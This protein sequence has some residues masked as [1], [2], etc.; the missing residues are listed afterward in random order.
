MEGLG[1]DLVA[2]VQEDQAVALAGEQAAAEPVE[3]VIDN[4][5]IPNAI[6]SNEWLNSDK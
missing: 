6:L 5:H 2:A 1:V 3:E 4:H